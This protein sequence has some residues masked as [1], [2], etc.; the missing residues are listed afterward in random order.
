MAEPQYIDKIN[1]I[2]SLYDIHDARLKNVNF[3]NLAGI[4]DK[5]G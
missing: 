3:L 5:T 1:V 4:S 2:G